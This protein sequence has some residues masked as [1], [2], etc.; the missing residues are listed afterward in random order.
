MNIFAINA[1]DPKIK[2]NKIK[3]KN[4]FFMGEITQD[5]YTTKQKIEQM[6]P[7]E[8]V[9]W[10]A[11]FVAFFTSVFAIFKNIKKP[12][13]TNPKNILKTANKLIQQLKPQDTSLAKEVFP[14]L[15]KNSKT[16]QIEPKDYNKILN[17]INERNKDFM[18]SEGLDLI[19]SKMEKMKDC[20]SDHVEDIVTLIGSINKNNKHI[21]NSVVENIKQ[22]KIAD[23]DDIQLFLEELKPEKHN[24]VFDEL[25]QKI[26]PYE[27]S[28]TI[29]T[30]KRYAKLFNVI[31]PQTEDII[32]KI[33]EFQTF[34][35]KHID[36]FGILTSV[37]EENIECV[38]PLLNNMEKLEYN[39]SEIK[40]LLKILNNNNA[41][42]IEPIAN[43][44]ENIKSLNLDVEELFSIL[45]DKNQSAIFNSIMHNTESFKI[46]ELS[47]IKSYL[48][49]L[50]LEIM[51]FI[52]KEV[53]PKLKGNLDVLGLEYSEQIADVISKI[54]PKT[55]QSIEIVT[56]Y[57]KKLGP[58]L[59]YNSLLEAITEENISKLPKLFENIKQT[60]VWDN[61]M[62]DS[63][64]FKKLLE[65]I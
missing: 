33:A 37:S 60:E 15:I 51:D 49:V 2:T 48:K 38:M 56:E 34:K 13:A 12:S 63:T 65:S 14:L 32:P 3:N 46:E 25:I 28:L 58:N 18:T 31:T 54:T 45:K 11:T 6:P 22:L 26:V 24:Y 23:V 62:V 61:F 64:D 27:K 50:K 4:P 55:V 36:K 53:M 16:L 44:I 39:S 40:N 8:K 41:H 47:D 30:P 52:N 7:K 43:N 19:A 20:I 9:G 42:S 1:T 21:F 57:A 29:N 59:S 10:A 17:G 5:V 35:N